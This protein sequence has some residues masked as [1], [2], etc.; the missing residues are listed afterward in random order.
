VLLR[1]ALCPVVGRVTMDQTLVDVTDLPQPPDIG[2]TATF[3]GASASHAIPLSRYAAW[4][5]QIEW[6]ALCSLSARTQRVYR[7]DTAV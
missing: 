6:E 4:S 5:G 1:D 3:I 7:T 2:E